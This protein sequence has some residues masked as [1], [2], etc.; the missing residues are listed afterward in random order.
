MNDIPQ[1][2]S[3]DT[4]IPSLSY[5]PRK[6]TVVL[7]PSQERTGVLEALGGPRL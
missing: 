3:H 4:R 6:P 1:F 2:L 7:L 5:R